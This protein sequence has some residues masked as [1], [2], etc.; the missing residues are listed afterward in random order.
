MPIPKEKC[1]YINGMGLSINPKY[2]NMRLMR[3]LFPS[4]III[5]KVRII[6]PT[7]NGISKISKKNNCLDFGRCC[8][9]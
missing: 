2:C 1:V 8:A 4:R 9:R 6:S 7:Q 5:A 3:P